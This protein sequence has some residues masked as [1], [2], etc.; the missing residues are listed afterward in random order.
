MFTG[1]EEVI[2]FSLIKKLYAM[3][4][5]L[6]Q[7]KTCRQ[8]ELCNCFFQQTRMVLSHTKVKLENIEH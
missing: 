7:R 3:L 2:C 4:S 5:D 8:A 6:L 1:V